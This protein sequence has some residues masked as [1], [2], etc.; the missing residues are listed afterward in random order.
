MSDVES[1]GSSSASI[2]P[3]GISPTRRSL[4][5][6]VGGATGL[7]VVSGGLL[8][9]CSSSSKKKDNSGSGGSTAN[10]AGSTVT[11]GSNYSDPAPKAAFAGGWV[12]SS[13]AGDA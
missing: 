12:Y 13:K 3:D 2:T 11:F 7:A 6:G 1:S 9:A 8:S 10:V 4:L 5:R